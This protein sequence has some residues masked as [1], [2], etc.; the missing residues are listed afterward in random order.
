M[1][2]SQSIWPD[3]EI[4]ADQFEIKGCWSGTDNWFN[5]F[6]SHGSN[7]V[8]ELGGVDAVEVVEDLKQLLSK[9]S[10]KK[11]AEMKNPAF[12]D[13]AGGM[14]AQYLGCVSF[15]G[16]NTIYFFM[17]GDSLSRIVVADGIGNVL[18]TFGV[19]SADQK[20]WLEKIN[21][22]SCKLGEL[23]NSAG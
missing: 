1:V 11:L 2:N 16:Y 21:E 14:D 9:K 3:F 13:F 17:Q 19:L 5:F 15:S 10:G 6:L 4:Q 7:G 22:F 12:L 20:R 23:N 8:V 18:C